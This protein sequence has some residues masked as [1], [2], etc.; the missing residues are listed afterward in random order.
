MPQ[1]VSSVILES[2]TEAWHICST[3]SCTGSMFRS[4]SSISSE[5]QFTGVSKARLPSTSWT[6]ATPHRTLPVV[7]DFDLPAATIFSYHDI[8]AARLAVRRS[9]SPVWWPPRPVAQC[10]QF[11]E[12]AKDA[13]VS[14]CTWT[15]SALEALHNVLYKFKTY[16]LTYL[17]F[18]LAFCLYLI[19]LHLRN[20]SF[21]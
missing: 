15:P 6:A 13:S 7:S 18:L 3:S 8:V 12:E 21:I 2:S 10:R 14:E 1:P 17:L 16:L 4:E 20:F 9:P 5:W 11:P 19:N